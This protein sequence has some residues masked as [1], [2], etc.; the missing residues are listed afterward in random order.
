M[1]LLTNKARIYFFHCKDQTKPKLN[2][3]SND[4]FLKETALIINRNFA[5]YKNF[6]RFQVKISLEKSG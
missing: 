2:E 3:N 1:Y 6:I 4:L 5:I